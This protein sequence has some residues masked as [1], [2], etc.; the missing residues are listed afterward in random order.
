MVYIFR[1]KEQL[2]IQFYSYHHV[3]LNIFVSDTL[4]YEL[5]TWSKDQSL[6]IWRIEPFLQK[7]FIYAVYEYYC[8]IRDSYI[9]MWTD[10]LCLIFFFTQLCGHER[11]V[12]HSMESQETEDATTVRTTLGVWRV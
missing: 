6:R 11:D 2:C 5:I 10:V 4:D 3:V 12:E 1:A 9:F 8:V 7:V